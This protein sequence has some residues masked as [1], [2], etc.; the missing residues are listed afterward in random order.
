MS[1]GIAA[2][3]T[4]KLLATAVL[5]QA[6]EL[7]L[8]VHNRNFVE[9]WSYSNL[10]LNL[11]GGLP[12]PRII[13]EKIFS[14]IGFKFLILSHVILA[15]CALFFLNFWIFLLL[16][17]IHLL[18][19]IR[20]RGTFNGG[21]DMMTTVVL[22]GVLISLFPA[23]PHAQKLGLLYIAVHSIFSYTKAG[24]VKIKNADW[25]SGKALPIFLS[26]SL[27]M[28][29]QNISR[30]LR[31]YPLLCQVLCWSVILFELGAISL[32][33]MS[34]YSAFYFMV[35]VLFHFIVFMS[36]GLNRFFWIWICTWP[37]IFYS[38]SLV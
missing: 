24:W 28:G 30:R 6:L 23:A 35:A 25:R 19:C 18:I 33:L 12:I 29:V 1:V 16:F 32:P 36:F 31:S 38:I 26:Q 2:M 17:I 27:I 21:S 34:V 4:S 14:F 5:F 10:K 20:F 13:I 11:E 8:L 22:T 37:S 7:L 3:I 15:L 9:I